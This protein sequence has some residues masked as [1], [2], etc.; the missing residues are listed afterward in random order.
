MMT[1]PKL[2]DTYA[3]FR[4]KPVKNGSFEVIDAQTNRSHGI[5]KAWSQAL[6][7]FLEDYPIDT[8]ITFQWTDSDCISF[9]PMSLYDWL[10]STS[11]SRGI[12]KVDVMNN[13][14]RLSERSDSIHNSF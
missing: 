3:L 14:R 12:V 6:E 8:L 9:V 10:H 13:L 1:D 11:N 5:C 2:S 7:G 4:L